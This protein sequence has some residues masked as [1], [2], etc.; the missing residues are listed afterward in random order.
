VKQ[1]RKVTIDQKVAVV[2]KNLKERKD[3]QAF[4]Q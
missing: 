3:H 4:H 2:V 1:N